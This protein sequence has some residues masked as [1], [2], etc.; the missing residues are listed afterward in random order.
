MSER[1]SAGALLRSPLVW[2]VVLIAGG[3]ALLMTFAYVGAFVNPVGRLD[4]L[5]VAVVDLDEP[6]D[7]AGQ[8]LAVGQRF[9]EALQE[10]DAGE[11]AIRVVV[12]PTEDEARAALAE[13]RVIG[14]IVLPPDLSARVGEVGTSIGAAA[15]A[16]VRLLTNEG[17][18]SLQPAVFERFS[19][20][21]V[22]RLAADASAQLTSV[23]TSLDVPVKAENVGSLARPVV[24]ADEAVVAIGDRGGRGLPPFY[25]AVMVTLTAIVAAT[26]LHVVTGVLTGAERLELLGRELSVR[27]RRATRGQRWVTEALVAV[28]IAA[29]GGAAIMWMSYGVLHAHV[30]QPATAT[31][32]CMIGVLALMWLAQGFLVAFGLIGD[33]LVLLL[34]TIFGVP[35]ARGVY[36]AEALPAF[37]RG[38]GDVLPLRWLTDGLRAAYFYDGSGAA[39]LTGA[40]VALAVYALVGLLFG[41]LATTVSRIRSGAPAAA[42]PTSATP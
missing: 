11:T 27:A 31:V 6:V 3:L 32:L 21:A 35:S 39:G 4:G 15:P 7:V 12:L 33:L 17:A 2:M 19:T 9:V 24:V 5:P 1:P 22:D 40:W 8:H 41:A 30:D 18:G 14:A 16:T 10:E 20:A 26:A 29:L 38:L 37:F 36:P 28:P 42:E 13:N 34:T 23:L 25:A